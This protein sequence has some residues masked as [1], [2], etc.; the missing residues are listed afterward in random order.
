M[1]FHLELKPTKSN[2]DVIKYI[3]Y[4]YIGKEKSQLS[5]YNVYYNIKSLKYHY[6]FP[7][8]ISPEGTLEFVLMSITQELINDVEKD[9]SKI[10]KDIV[11][12]KKKKEMLEEYYQ[13]M[14]E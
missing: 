5:C 6:V 10:E 4:S 2:N 14:E 11:I 13:S 3:I 1:S 8:Y 12:L 9:I 7:S